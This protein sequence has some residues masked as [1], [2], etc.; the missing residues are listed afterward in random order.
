MTA[1]TAEHLRTRVIFPLGTWPVPNVVPFRYFSNERY[2]PRGSR[3]RLFSP[4]SRWRT[5]SARLA[6]VITNHF[7]SYVPEIARILL[8]SL[9]T[10]MFSF[11]KNAI[12]GEKRKAIAE[13]ETSHFGKLRELSVLLERS[14]SPVRLQ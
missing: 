9:S 1:A 13:T 12:G 14:R 8:L 11:Q 4:I 6:A 2:I 5:G 7:E 3:A 10:M